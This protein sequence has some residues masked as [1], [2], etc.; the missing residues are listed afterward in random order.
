MGC[1]KLNKSP[2]WEQKSNNRHKKAMIRRRL[3]ARGDRDSHS[4]FKEFRPRS[5]GMLK[6]SNTSSVLD[7]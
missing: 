5:I 7:I 4:I 2:Q 3:G 6:Q 1:D